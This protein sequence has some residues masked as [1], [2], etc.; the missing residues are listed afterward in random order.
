MSEP[1]DDLLEIAGAIA[2]GGAVDWSAA[3]REDMGTVVAG[4]RRLEALRALFGAVASRDGDGVP[5]DQ[6]GTWGHLEVRSG[7]GEGAFGSV[8]RAFEPILRREVALKLWREGDA[9]HASTLMEE[10]RSLATVRHPHVLAVYGAD[11]HSG[12]L[13]MWT[14]LLQGRTLEEEL[15]SRGPLSFPHWL[16]IALALAGALDAVHGADLA[17]GD[18]KASNVMVDATGRV[19]LTDFGAAARVATGPAKAGSPLSMAPEQLAGAPLDGAADLFALGVLLYRLAVARYPFEASTLAELE[20]LHSSGARARRL[21][22]SLP[23]RARRL[24]SALLDAQ[25]TNRPSATAALAELRW[26]EQAPQRRRL[27][28]ATA[29][30]ATALVLLLLAS[31]GVAHQAREKAREAAKAEEVKDFLASLFSSADPDE[32]GGETI[33]AR[34]L[35]DRGGHFAA[36]EYPELFATELRAAFASLR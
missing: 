22:R 12:R 32:S 23:R 6:P 11:V 3:G 18:V 19:V 35:L 7:L 16:E 14:E 5:P 9:G 4:F 26:I 36:W 13:G 24:M 33:T 10:A 27:R 34:E 20:A 8:Y 25:P 21:P 28:L 2:D 17:H 31:G 29:G 30:T 15:A 1:G